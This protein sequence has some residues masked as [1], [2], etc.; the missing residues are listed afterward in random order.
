MRLIFNGKQ[1]IPKSDRQNG[2]DQNGGHGR[3]GR[4][5]ILNVEPIRL[6]M[7]GVDPRD[8]NPCVSLKVEV[9]SRPRTFT[10]VIDV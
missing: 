2:V 10:N 4:T 9:L 1:C 7:I 3:R 6:L 5:S 8:I